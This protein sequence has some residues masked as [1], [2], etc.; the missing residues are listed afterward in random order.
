MPKATNTQKSMMRMTLGT[1]GNMMGRA[2]EGATYTGSTTS[3]F[4]FNFNFQIHRD[5]L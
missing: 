3:K 4:N 2:E 5:V 1:S